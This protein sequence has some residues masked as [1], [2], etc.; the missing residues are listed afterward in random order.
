ME[1]KDFFKTQVDNPP[2]M[3]MIMKYNALR[4]DKGINK[5]VFVE[6]SSD[7]RFYSSTN[8]DELSRDSQYIYQSYEEQ[9]GG[10]EAV[11]YAFNGIKTNAD[12]ISDMKRCIFIV[13]RDWEMSIKSKNN[14]ISSKDRDKFTVTQGHS[15]ECYFLEDEN[16]KVVF[17]QLGIIEQLKEFRE[18]LQ[19]FKNKTYHFWALKGTLQYADKHNIHVHYRRRYKWED[20]FK[21]DFSK[22]DY[23][24]NG[25]LIDE[26][27][28]MEE[29]LSGN[30]ELM[31]YCRKWD[32][33]IQ[34][35]PRFIRGHD[36]FNLLI[37]YINQ[38]CNC[39]VSARR[40]Y[41]YVNEFKVVLD[42]KE[43]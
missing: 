30:E 5:L 41:G 35:E 20:I 11:F 6:G 40:L 2:P 13:D 31:N 18:I 12:L 24:E 43:C 4:I 29:S 34:D 7:S 33:K 19:D 21:F 23:F 15:M 32:S 8:I 39:N 16:L 1:F 14:L 27:M 22:E 42:I 26:I 3:G 36:Y 10:K 28:Q 17:S 25:K 9:N 38:R 37:S